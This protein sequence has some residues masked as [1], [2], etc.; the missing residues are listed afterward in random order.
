MARKVTVTIDLRVREDATQ[1]ELDELL[2]ALM[3]QVEDD[4]PGALEGFDLRAPGIPGW[5]PD[6]P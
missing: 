1:D 5:D 4:E 2:G 6:R 3:A